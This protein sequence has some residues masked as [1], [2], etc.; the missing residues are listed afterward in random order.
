MSDEVVAAPAS[1][2]WESITADDIR[3]RIEVI[4]SREP[5]SSNPLYPREWEVVDPIAPGTNTTYLLRLMQFNLLAEGLSCVAGTQA[6]NPNPKK[7]PEGGNFTELPK[8][9]DGVIGSEIL[10]FATRKF[11]IVEEILSKGPDILTVQELDRF[12][13]FFQPVLSK[14]GYDG[15]FSPKADSP[16]LQFGFYSDGV[17]IFWKREKFTLTSSAIAG[18]IESPTYDPIDVVYAIVKLHPKMWEGT[19]VCVATCHLK[20]KSSNE[21][22]R[23]AQIRSIL[24]L[25]RNF[26]TDNPT[27]HIILA[28]DFNT[29][30]CD[31]V[32]FVA[33]VIPWLGAEHKW[34][35]SSY[36]LDKA[37]TYVTDDDC[38]W[39]WTT[40]K[41]RAQ[42]DP[43]EIKHAIDYIFHDRDS[44]R[45][46]QILRPPAEEFI[47]DHRLP[48]W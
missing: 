23:M 38:K 11:R 43:S 20:A 10:D 41:K 16:C 46:I 44:F 26:D 47:M 31:R 14:F 25:I 30:P 4:K 2:Y 40:W 37:S 32:G 24:E 33:E 35:K 1:S 27:K 17:A 28:G 15:I 6:P 39:L 5:Y 9:P 12:G 34:L 42:S 19:D 36:P 29:D 13:D 7:Q 45:T 21:A 48:C 8:G 22:K 3:K 18:K